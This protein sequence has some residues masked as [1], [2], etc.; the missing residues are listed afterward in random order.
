V[1][2]H[3]IPASVGVATGPLALDRESA[4]R[5][6]RG[7]TPPVLVRPDTLTEEVA[8]IAVAAGLLTGHG[9]RTSH[10]AVVARELGKPCLV[11]CHE[12]DLDLTARTA[13]IGGRMFAEGDLLCLDAEAGLVY[14][15]APRV[16]EERP[17]RELAQLE[18]W[19]A[20]RSANNEASR[21]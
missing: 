10:A 15:G 2:C 19:Q 1:I 18:A 17:I 3:A 16:I 12:L 7:G 5:I 6:A 9:S 13:R 21:G 14:G 11:G 4:D 8:A 20:A